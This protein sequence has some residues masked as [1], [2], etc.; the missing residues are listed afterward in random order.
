MAE[1]AFSA[2]ALLLVRPARE[3]DLP[4]TAIVITIDVPLTIWRHCQLNGK[5]SHLV[6]Q[7]FLYNI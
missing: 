5:R 6:G 3:H 2:L 1:A 7:I 4:M